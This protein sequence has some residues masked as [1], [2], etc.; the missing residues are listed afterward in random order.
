VYSRQPWTLSA[1]GLE[2]LRALAARTDLAPGPG[3][4]RI[5]PV[6]L[7]EVLPWIPSA[8]TPTCAALIALYPSS[9]LV[10]HVD[11][12]LPGRRLHIPLDVNDGCW[13]FSAGEWVRLQVGHVYAMYPEVIHGAV[14]WGATR[15]VHL[16]LD[17]KEG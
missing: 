16:L 5:T 17:L 4:S 3:G 13:S 11:Q 8:P 2:A 14:N 1:G 10:A 15:R 6:P 12:P 9:Q 7:A